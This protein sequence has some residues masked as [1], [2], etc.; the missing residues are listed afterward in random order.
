MD[1]YTKALI[2]LGFLVS[3]P[4]LF[5]FLYRQGHNKRFGLRFREFASLKSG[6]FK[7]N[8]CIPVVEFYEDGLECELK[9]NLGTTRRPAFLFVTVKDPGPFFL[10]V[11]ESK[12]IQIS[13]P[14]TSMVSC[15]FEDGFGDRFSI[16]SDAEE[17][18]LELLHEELRIYLTKLADENKSPELLWDD[19]GLRY[20]EK[21]NP[22]LKPEDVTERAITIYRMIKG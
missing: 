12:P 16:M 13:F 11:I 9:A 3:F 4:F 21:D 2:I 5:F 1:I 7:F 6:R 18:S 17:K 14:G 22:E 10:Q 8:I 19:D 20:S 15:S